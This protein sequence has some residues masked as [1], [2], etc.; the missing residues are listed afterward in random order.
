MKLDLSAIRDQKHILVYKEFIIMFLIGND[1]TK[2][3]FSS[4]TR[5][6]CI[7]VHESILSF[8][9]TVLLTGGMVGKHD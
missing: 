3:F 5:H 1:E 7:L 2:F 9:V 6:V 4:P 8:S